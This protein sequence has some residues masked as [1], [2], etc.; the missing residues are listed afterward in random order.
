MITAEDKSKH[1]FIVS[2]LY[3]MISHLNFLGVT[4]PCFY[5]RLMHLPVCNVTKFW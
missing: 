1:L 5:N 4:F 3:N 2:S